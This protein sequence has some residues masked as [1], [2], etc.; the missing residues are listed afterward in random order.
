M[1]DLVRGASDWVWQSL[2][3]LREQGKE[4][5]RIVIREVSEMLPQGGRAY[6]RLAGL[7]GATAV[8]MGAYGAHAF[9]QSAKSPELKLTYDT[10]NRYHLIHSAVLLA[11]PLTK[12][13]N[14]VGPLLSLGILLFSGSC[15]YHAMTENVTIRK[16]TPYGGMLLIAGWAAMIL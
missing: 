6:V 16:V 12:R 10:G 15:Y 1:R 4:V 7:S 2:P 11:V 14:L 5:E 9:R 8:I 3:A 13:P